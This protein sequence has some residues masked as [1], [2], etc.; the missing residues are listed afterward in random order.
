M[1]TVVLDPGHGGTTKVGGSSPNNATGPNGLLEKTVTLQVAFAAEKALRAAGETVLLTRHI[2]ENIGIVERAAVAKNAHAAAFVSL[3]FNA[4]G[5]ATPAQGTET[6]IGEGHTRISRELADEVQAKVRAATG[7]RNRGV[8]VGNVSGV[9]KPANHDPGTANC[10]VEISFLSL[11]PDE[12]QR[13][14]DPAYIEKL[15][16]AVADGVLSYLRSHGLTASTQA[17][18]REQPDDAA[19]ARRLGLIQ[20]EPDADAQ[21]EV[22]APEARTVQV[23]LMLSIG[24]AQPAASESRPVIEFP[25]AAAKELSDVAGPAAGAPMISAQTAMVSSD[26]LQAKAE[27]R[28]RYLSAMPAT[29]F[30]ARSA[31]TSPDPNLNVVGIGIG[32]KVSDGSPTGQMGVKLLV[33]LKYAPG[34]VPADH[35]L[36]ET[37]AGLPVDIEEVGT[38]R[39]L[40]TFP[41]PRLSKTPAQPGSS[42]GFE[43]SDPNF[44][45]A[46]TF[47]ALVRDKQGRV[48]VLSNNHVLANEDQLA[49][50][51]SIF[52]T[53]LLDL[54]PGERKRM[55]ATLDRFV[56]LAQ[57]PRKVDA[58]LAI[59]TD[60]SLVSNEVLYIGPPQGTMKAAIDMVVHKFGRTTGYTVGR[61][62]SLA[63]DITV[64]YERGDLLFEDQILIVGRNGTTFSDAGDSGSLIM[65]RTGNRAVGLLFAGSSSHTIANHID[66]VLGALDIDLL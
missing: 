20:D 6:W 56:P 25:R 28:K 65:E 19:S 63:T 62:T 21:A 47:G 10:L 17:A 54:P 45:M 39:A 18:E 38:I 40:A 24:F 55:I 2:D 22:R 61:I 36:P 59:P 7:H 23:P 13:L 50:G 12:E 8:K 5:G 9:I 35:Q 44:L 66:D 43:L 14:R 58:A 26:L 64:G 41:N 1:A 49:S 31:A 3:H 4:P 42:I 16:R 29:T 15:G 52:Q 48:C 46:G 32:E 51:A 60:K 11:Q 30:R 57:T 53:G 27:M 33:R 37:I 34:S